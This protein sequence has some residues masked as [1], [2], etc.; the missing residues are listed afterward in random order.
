VYQLPPKTDAR[1]R[2]DLEK[3]LHGRWLFHTDATYPR[4]EELCEQG[5]T[6]KTTKLTE[7]FD[8]RAF[9]EQNGADAI[10]LFV[11]TENM[12]LV[13]LATDER[14][15]PRPGQ[16]LISLVLPAEARSAAGV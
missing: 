8:F 4:L 14:A 2:S 12:R 10:P 9:R 3:H 11:V 1:G 7:A 16:T 15:E 13:V 5:A 6:V